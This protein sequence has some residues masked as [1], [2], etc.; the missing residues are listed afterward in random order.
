MSIKAIEQLDQEFVQIKSEVDIIHN[1]INESYKTLDKQLIFFN[2]VDKKI[3]EISKM[4]IKIKLN[5]GGEIYMIRPHILLSIEDSLFYVL[6]LKAYEGGINLEEHEFFFD[7]DNK[8]F[9]LVVEL[10]TYGSCSF[11]PKDSK[12]KDVINEEFEYYGVV[13]IKKRQIN[14]LNL[15][16][17]KII[18]IINVFKIDKYS[19]KEN[20]SFDFNNAENLI[21]Y[22]IPKDESIVFEFEKEET[23]DKVRL[24]GYKKN[25]NSSYG[26]KSIILSSLDGTNYNKILTLPRNYKSELISL[27]STSTKAKFIKFTAV[28]EDL[29]ISF[30]QFLN[31]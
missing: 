13:N 23:L 29:G 2:D 18:K 22:I 11:D 1:T 14:A 9:S 12:I 28:I 24:I 27:S 4:D 5:I 25:K 16:D 20:V 19:K 10:L 26:K 30:I 31:I 3:E 21:G 17:S 6:I 8:Y 7:R 15:N